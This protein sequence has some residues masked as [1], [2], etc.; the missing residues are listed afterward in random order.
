MINQP[1]SDIRESQAQCLGQVLGKYL[2]SSLATMVRSTAISQAAKLPIPVSPSL[3]A[4]FPAPRSVWAQLCHLSSDHLFSA[5]LR[6]PG[7]NHGS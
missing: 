2:V 3:F 5:T 4:L 1:V 7:R 6:S